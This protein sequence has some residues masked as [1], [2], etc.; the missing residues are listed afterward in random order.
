MQQK[1]WAA[2]ASMAVATMIMSPIPFVILVFLVTWM[3]LHGPARK[4][5]RPLSRMLATALALAL[6]QEALRHLVTPPTPD[7]AG[8][9][10]LRWYFGHIW[11]RLSAW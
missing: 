9:F 1:W 3:L 11:D 2:T 8:A 4:H 7:Q 10:P 5:W 6:A